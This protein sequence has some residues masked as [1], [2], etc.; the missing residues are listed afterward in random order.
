MVYGESKVS[1]CEIMGFVRMF[2]KEQ[3]PRDLLAKN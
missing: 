3:H 1:V 2:R